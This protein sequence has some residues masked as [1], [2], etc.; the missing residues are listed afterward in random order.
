MVSISAFNAAGDGPRSAPTRGQ[1]QQAGR[2]KVSG[3]TVCGDNGTTPGI[4][5]V[6]RSRKAGF[7]TQVPLPDTETEPSL[8]GRL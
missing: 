5:A 3:K 7:G 4:K 2:E 1:T 8:P 6:P